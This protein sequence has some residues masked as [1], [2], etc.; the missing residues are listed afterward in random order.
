[1]KIAVINFS[2]NTGKTTLTKNLLVPL[3]PGAKRISIE[4]VNEGDGAVDLQIG[5]NRFRNLAAELNVADDDQHIVM[6]IGASTGKAMVAELGAL[7]TTRRIFDFWIVPVVPSEKERR[8]TLNTV[9]ALLEIKVPADRIVVIANNLSDPEMFSVDFAQLAAA[10][11][12]LGFVLCPQGIL[13]HK[14]FDQI[15]GWD[16]SVFDVVAKYSEDYLRAERKAAK[17]DEA[18]LEYVGQLMVIRD[19]A[20]EACEQL[21]D[22]FAVTPMGQELAVEA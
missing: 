20:E 3:I 5:A 22:V 16:E 12:E 7:R 17:G 6:D 1:M 18:K 21:R 4:D 13:Q 19:A 9:K 2:G 10:A 8:D 15:K 11:G 14:V